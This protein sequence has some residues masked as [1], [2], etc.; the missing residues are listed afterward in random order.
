MF[1]MDRTGRYVDYHA[2]DPRLLFVPPEVF[3]GRT[4][5]DVMP[6]KLAEIFM[7]A[8][9][10][11][12]ES[13]E[14]VLVNYELPL[15]GEVRHFEA[16]LIK[17]D[18]QRVV[19]IV[20]DVTESKRAQE[21]NRALAGRLIVSQEE[22]RQRIA[23]ELHDDLG[24]RLALLNVD[25]EQMADE[26]QIPRTQ[27]EHLSSQVEEIALNLSHLSHDLH[28]SRL[29]TLGLV[30]SVRVLCDEISEQRRVTVRFSADELPGPVDPAVAL[31]LYRI[32]QE[33]LRNVAKHSQAGHASVHLSCEGNDVQLQIADSGAGFDPFAVGQAGLGLVSM[34][35]RVSI[36]K[37]HIAVD[38]SPGCGTRIS[39]RVPLTPPPPYAAD[40]IFESV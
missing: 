21:L 5:R 7:D 27:L 36:L 8:L 37:G 19:S 11:T 32:T 28:P 6:P 18:S 39:V 17:S 12:G 35:E 3:L 22:E 29:R 24:Q 33:A 9:D 20:R 15:N 10:R 31:C 2:R 34:R 25:V 23:R 40:P 16:R 4:I 14:P 38:A 30:E 1:V 26:L 13:D